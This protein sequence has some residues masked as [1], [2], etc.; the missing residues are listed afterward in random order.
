MRAS[1]Y[2][3][4]FLAYVSL[5]AQSQ[6][7]KDLRYIDKVPIAIKKAGFAVQLPMKCGPDG[8]VYVR[9]AE[10]DTEPAVTLISEDGKLVSSIHLSAI[11]EFSENDF[12]DFAPAGGEVFVLSANGRPHIP[13]TYYLSRFKTD[14][15]Y[16]SSSTV[17]ISFRPDFEPRQIAAFPSGNLLVAG[18]VRGHDVPFAPFTAIFTD[19]GQFLREVTFKQDVTDQ[20]AKQEPSEEKLPWAQQIRDLLDVTFLQTADDGNVYLMRHTP[21][22]PVFAVSPGGSVRRIVLKPPVQGADLQW[23]LVNNGSVAAQYR[24]PRVEQDKTHYLVLF[25]MAAHRVRQT[26]RYTH[27][28]QT[29]GGGMT[30]YQNGVFTFIAGGPNGALQLVK[31]AAQ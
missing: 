16:I 23:V 25:D 5:A 8:T 27:N 3:L 18:M 12:L 1:K 26:V 19:S 17:D 31:A 14:G 7:F 6:D 20:D 28:Y 21:Q 29:T 11:P 30:C 13:T 24:S 10:A 22:G 4:I 15:T 2:F 9:F